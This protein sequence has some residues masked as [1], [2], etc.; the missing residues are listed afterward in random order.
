MEGVR[1]DDSITDGV[2]DQGGYPAQDA[3]QALLNRLRHAS[4]ARGTPR[5]TATRK[6]AKSTRRRSSPEPVYG[7]RDP[8]GVGNVFSRMLA[9][10]GWKSPVAV[11]SVL[12]RWG[13]IVGAEI[14]AHCVPE[15]FDSDTVLVR[16]D[17]TAWATQLRLVTPQVLQR[18]EAEL[19]PGVVTRL[20]VVG[21]AAPSWRKG[22]RTVKGRGP[23]D[24]YG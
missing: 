10:R 8:E 19:G 13:E 17:S 6:A 9:D 21:P 12:A 3:P 4:Q 24:T 16:C 22:G 11:G 14:A 7:G 18:F 15:S 1:A 2:D 20:S 5:E 23:R